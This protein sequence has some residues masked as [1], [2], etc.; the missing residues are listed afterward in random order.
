MSKQRVVIG[1]DHAGFS[2]KEALKAHMADQGIDVMDEG[3]FSDEPVDYP[4][5]GKK[6]AGV[7]LTEKIPGVFLGGSG[8]GESI[9]GNKIPGIRAARCTTVEDAEMSR[10]HNDANMLCMGGRMIDEDSAKKALDAFLNTE[11]EGERHL[12]RVKQIH[13]LDGYTYP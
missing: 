1:T 13:E 2:L 5:I 6:V 10:K 3:T 9:A 11:F 12:E 7:M 8:I 4:P